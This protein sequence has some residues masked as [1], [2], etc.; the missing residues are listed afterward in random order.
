MVQLL[1]YISF[2]IRVLTI[3]QAFDSVGGTDGIVKYTAS[4]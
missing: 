1:S 4:E 3:I 2:P